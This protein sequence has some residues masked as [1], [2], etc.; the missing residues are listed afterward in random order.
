M[1]PLL[2]A[3]S[4]LLAQ[5]TPAPAPPAE[6]LVLIEKK[7][8]EREARRAPLERK[9]REAV[10]RN[11]TEVARRLNEEFNE[12]EAA[13]DALKKKRDEIKA[14]RGTSWTDNVKVSG[15]AMLTRFDKGLD[16]KDQFG[17]GA[18]VTLGKHLFF[19]YQRWETR[20]EQGNAPATV[21]SYQLGLTGEQGFGLE[22]DITF[23]LSAGVGLAHFS[24]DATRCDTGPIVSLRPEWKY[25][26]NHRSSFSLGGDFDFVWTDFNNPHTHPR[27]NQSLFLSIEFAF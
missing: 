21:Q 22:G 20:D 14:A 24:S 6:D 15:Q 16:L 17:W 2:F 4:L 5:E 23:A 3:T 26:F 27:E 13:I 18:S 19:E 12:N 1:S 25:Y 11:E 9:I 8:A 7:I 10:D